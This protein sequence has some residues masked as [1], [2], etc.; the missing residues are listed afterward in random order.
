MGAADPR[1]FNSSDLAELLDEHGGTRW[2]RRITKQTYLVRSQ[3]LEV[4]LE[5]NRHDVAEGNFG[6]L[7]SKAT[8]KY[9]M[10]SAFER[11]GWKKLQM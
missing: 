5:D 1:L 3:P 11:F 2:C 6:F 8:Y 9:C 7:R 4:L 10:D